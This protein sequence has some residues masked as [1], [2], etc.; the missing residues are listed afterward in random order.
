MNDYQQLITLIVSVVIL[1]VISIFVFFFGGVSN[2]LSTLESEVTSLENDLAVKR[3][4]I[5]KDKEN[6]IY[7]TTGIR[8]YQIRDDLKYFEEYIKP[9]FEWVD[10]ETYNESREK[11][12]KDLGEKSSFVDTY[13]IENIEIDGYTYVDVNDIKSKYVKTE[14]YP[15]QN[16]DSDKVIDYLGVVQFYVYEEEQDLKGLSRLP[17]NKAFL[18]F[19]MEDSESGDERVVRKLSAESGFTY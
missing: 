12:V 4:G 7:K 13:L 3:D 15:L 14:L 19:T 1:V 5:Q 16:S 8:P 18:R 17:L 10:G 11:Y 9:A 2:D 6:I